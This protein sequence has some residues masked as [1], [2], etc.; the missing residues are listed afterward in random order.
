MGIGDRDQIGAAGHYCQDQTVPG[1]WVTLPKAFGKGVAGDFQL[2]DLQRRK[3]SYGP[4]LSQ[5]GLWGPRLSH[6]V[7]SR[8]RMRR[9]WGSGPSAHTRKAR[10]WDSR[11]IMG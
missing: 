10:G 2:G 9:P 3:C 7:L 6:P 1:V 11:G 4:A 5:G 8:P